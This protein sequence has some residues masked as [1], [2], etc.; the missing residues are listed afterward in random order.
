MT[1]A[2]DDEPTHRDDEWPTMTISPK[3]R[4]VLGQLSGLS[5]HKRWAILERLTRLELKR[6]KEALRD[7]A[8]VTT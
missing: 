2:A 6:L 8:N 1:N 7:Q 3:T 4:Y 5:G